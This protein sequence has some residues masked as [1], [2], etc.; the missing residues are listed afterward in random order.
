[1]QEKLFEPL[2]MIDP[3]YWMVDATG[4]EMAYAGLN[5]T[6][7]DFAKLGELY[8]NHGVWQGRQIVPRAWVEASVTAD[9]PHLANGRPFSA[10]IP[11][12]SAM[13]SSGGCRMARTAS[14]AGLVSATSLSMSIRHG[15]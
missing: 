10:T 9:A 8:R 15:T 14:S 7:R 11:C 4:M 5:L 3:G 13:A 12:R 2:G 1:M 6:A